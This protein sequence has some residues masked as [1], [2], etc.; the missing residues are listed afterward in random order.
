MTR[1]AGDARVYLFQAL[2][3]GTMTIYI[4]K[5]GLAT[6]LRKELMEVLYVPWIW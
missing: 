3:L 4:G 1:E 2:L 5:N 6:T